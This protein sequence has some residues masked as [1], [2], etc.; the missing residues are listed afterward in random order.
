M[1]GNMT[2]GIDIGGT[3]IE[4][5]LA[6]PTGAVH[7]TCRISARPGNDLVVEDTVRVARSLTEEPVPVGIGIP[8]QIDAEH[9]VVRNVVNL[10]ITELAL[11]D[12]V[13]AR[14]GAPVRIEN[15]VNAAAL[16]AAAVVGGE[17]KAGTGTVVFLNLGTGLAAGIVRDGRLDRGSTG[18]IGEIGHVPVDPNRLPCP[19]GQRGCLETVACGGA[20]A[21][22][23][24]S[25][26]PAM[27]DILRRAAQGDPEARRV[28][29]MVLHAIGDALQ[30]V[31]QAYDPRLIL[32]GGGMART[33]APLFD[34]IG[35]EMRRRAEGCPFLT[36]LDIPSRVRPVP[37]GAPI[38]AIGA[39][40]AAAEE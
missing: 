23:W 37:D 18:A 6:D 13:G 26:D 28:R 7:A 35:A 20:V 2:I 11:A 15:D 3:K 19:C 39:A 25:A 8:G 17:R 1:D 21:R 38:G 32:V 16:G 31:A 30:I 9:G 14:L 12:E 33:G 27:P 22:L 34:A 29:D 36:T 5:V 24:P 40:L 10:G 4:G